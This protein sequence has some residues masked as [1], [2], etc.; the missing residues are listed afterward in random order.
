[1]LSSSPRSELPSA[2]RATV[3]KA[4]QMDAVMASGRLQPAVSG[5]APLASFQDKGT[6]LD[7]DKGAEIIA[8]GDPAKYCFEVVEG[9][10]RSVRQLEDGRRQ[11][12]EFLYAGD[13]FGLD[14]I[15]EH[16][17]AAEAVTGV[18]I[19]RLPL[20]LVELRAQEDAGFARYLRHHLALQAKSMRARLVELG[21][22]TAA[23]RVAS[24]L[25]TMQSRPG[26]ATRNRV[27]LPMCRSDIADY[28]GLTIETVSRNLTDL[29]RS[30]AI[31]VQGASVVINDRR[32][33][34]AHETMH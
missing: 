4:P 21:R 23:E 7:F 25:L 31:A 9:C 13:F 26:C 2:P 8:Q 6:L 16:E 28:L 15:G 33:L 18:T 1:M 17:F 3:M 22:M 10:V 32:S 19:R 34:G 29:K 12:S 5:S 24:F 27:D 20:S 30:G 11:V 14:A